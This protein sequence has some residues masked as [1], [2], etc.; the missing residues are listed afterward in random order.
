MVSRLPLLGRSV[1]QRLPVHDPPVRP[2]Y[3]GY[4]RVEDFREKGGYPRSPAGTPL[5]QSG[6]HYRKNT[7]S[8]DRFAGS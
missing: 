8:R 4:Q 2:R 3:P 1:H 5:Q 7:R 6:V